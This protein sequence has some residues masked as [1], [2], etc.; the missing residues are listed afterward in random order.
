VKRLLLRSIDILFLARPV[1]LIPVWSFS[2]F[3]YWCGA[4][5]GRGFDITL[6]WGKEAFL[7]HTGM[8]LFSFSVGAVYVLNQIADYDVDARND[9]FP[10][11]VK[12]GITRRAAF[13]YTAL[14]S[15]IS[16]GLPL[17]IP[18]YP[19]SFFSFAAL[20]LGTVYSFKPFYLS[21]RIFSDFLANATGYGLIAF[22]VGWYLASGPS[23]MSVSFFK[24]ALPYF[25]LM[26]GGSIS[27][28]LPDVPADKALGKRTTAVVLGTRRA[29]A[30]TILFVIIGGAVALM[31]KD[32]VAGITAVGALII[33]LLYAFVQTRKFMEATSK[34]SSSIAMA[35][36][37]IIYPVFIPWVLFVLIITRL[38]FRLRHGVSYPSLVPVTNEH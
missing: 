4:S 29:H 34:V 7:K 26:C 16:I 19:L 35:L 14:L 6:L 32:A 11:L 20:F 27:S 31:N 22:G 23:L 15:C 25:F 3:G 18:D 38:Y 1:I 5:A 9:G 10:L 28:T 13:V 24:A 33:D 12:S 17:A 30:L 2:I 8:M 21:G 36:A 37:G